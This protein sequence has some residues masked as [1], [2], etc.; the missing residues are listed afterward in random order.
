M[1]VKEE[2]RQKNEALHGDERDLQQRKQQPVVKE[3]EKK[4]LDPQPLSIDILEASILEEFK[5]LN[6]MITKNTSQPSISK[7]P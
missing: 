4:F 5:P 7:W 1:A 3:E 2:L 6:I